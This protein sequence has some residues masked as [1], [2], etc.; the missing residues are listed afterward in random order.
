MPAVRAS[1][2]RE[3]AAHHRLDVPE[4]A[5]PRYS[6][7][8][9]VYGNEASIPALLDRLAAM[10]QQLSGPLEAVF[11]VDGSPDRSLELLAER[12][13]DQPF[14]SRLIVHS[15]NFGALAA[16]RTALA[17]ASGCVA[18][19]MAA[20]L[21][22][23]PEL[24]LE[25]F[26]ILDADEADVVLGVRGDRADPAVTAVSSR[27]FW[28]LY[29]R[30]VNRDVPSGGVDVFACNE[31]FRRELVA[32]DEDNSSIVALALWLGFRRRT[33]AYDRR[34]REH[35]R[36][37]WTLRRRLKYLSDSVFSFTDLP[38]RLLLAGGLAGVLASIMLALGVAI[39]R[40]TGAIDVPGYAATIVVIAFFAALNLSGLG[41]IGAYVWR[42]F[43][44]TK[45]RPG[46]VVMAD[47]RFAGR[48]DA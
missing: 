29:R 14:S 41:I 11:V 15:R 13:P 18:G 34:R 35:G 33:V 17:H 48:P 8:I 9:P 40:L 42:A 24:M 36:S 38:I 26:R 5:T 30:L 25:C 39:A 6:I 21:Q 37:G 1:P 2:G 4:A 43:E 31:R 12:L 44:N 20:D 27:I 45:R 7:C 28:A 3:T 32:L 23:P 19:T 47:R 16:V 46:A 22:E 10:G